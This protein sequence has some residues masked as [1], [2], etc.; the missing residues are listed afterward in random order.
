MSHEI[1]INADQASFVSAHTPAWH[2]L[3]VT[4]DHTFT[5]EEAMKEG[6]LGGWNVRKSPV[7]T[8]LP[9][10]K[11]IPLPGRHAVIRDNPIIKGK[12]DV[13]GNVGDSY[14]IIQNEEHADLLN[15]LVDES[16]AHFETA[17][18]LYGG[19]RTF[20]TMK[21]PGHLK[22]GGVD[23]IENYISAINSHD[24]S[25][26][27]ILMTTPV[28]VVCANTL[29]M[30]FGNHSHM[31]RVRHTSGAQKLLIQQARE[32]LDLT[33]QYLEG[34]QEQA[35]M[36]IQTTMTQSQFEAI[37]E[38]EFGAPKDSASSTVTRTEAKLEKMAHLFAE[39]STQ[40]GIRDTAWAGLNAM[41]EWADHF[42]PTRGLTPDLSRAQKAIL[43]PSF[44]NQAL[45]IMM[46]F[47]STP[48]KAPRSRSKKAMV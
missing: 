42:S 36:L 14:K 8:T 27:F 16:G 41:T 38:K 13:L 15:T 37:I 21:M 28:R 32:A 6:H 46:K 10:G 48:Q 22:V 25:S 18:A 47:A 7:F 2:A 12:V 20:I 9:D 30:A 29:N 4:L 3:G 26:S 45:G 33:F 11:N 23:A 43:D 35:E 34:F 40:K 1:D 44:K 19:S 24:G 31:F 5:A 17:G 39:A